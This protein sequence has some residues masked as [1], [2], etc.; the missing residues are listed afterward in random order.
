MGCCQK[1]KPEP[2]LIKKTEKSEKI[3][4]MENNDNI[5]KESSEKKEENKSEQSNRH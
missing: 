4:I 3:G 5:I 1:K 2:L